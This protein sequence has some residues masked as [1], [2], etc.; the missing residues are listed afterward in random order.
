MSFLM[1]G[2][3]HEDIDQRFSCISRTLKH[4]ARSLPELHAVII[5]SMA[6]MSV[7]ATKLGGVFDI[8]SWLKPYLNHISQHTAQHASRYTLSTM[9]RRN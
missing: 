1:V 3:T 9:A 6:N 2:H 4:D 5:I 8:K 7:E